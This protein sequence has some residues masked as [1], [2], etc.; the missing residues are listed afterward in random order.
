MVDSAP[1]EPFRGDSNSL[2]PVWSAVGGGMGTEPPIRLIYRRLRSLMNVLNHVEA[3]HAR[4]L[5]ATHARALESA[6]AAAASAAAVV[7]TLEA[8]ASALTAACL[9]AHPPALGP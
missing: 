5:E 6:A 4:A 8:V 1:F 2:N 7:D 3:T 9:E